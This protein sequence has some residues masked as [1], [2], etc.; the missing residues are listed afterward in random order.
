MRWKTVRTY[1]K[2]LATPLIGYLEEINSADNLRQIVQRLPFH[3]RTK[4]VELADQIQQS[5]QRTNIAHIAEFVKV[6]ARAA[7]K[8][9]FGCVVD[10]VRDRPENLRRNSRGGTS[11]KER[12]S[13]FNTRETGA[14]PSLPS[15]KFTPTLRCPSG[16][17]NHSLEKCNSFKD[18]NFGK[19]MR[20]AQLCFN[21]F[22]Y[23]H[24]GVGR[25]AKSA[26]E[27]QGCRR[28]HHTLL[29]PPSPQQMVETE[30]LTKEFKLTVVLHY[31]VDRPTVPQLE[32]ERCA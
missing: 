23:S 5:G 25:L 11:S 7:N 22:K 16:N 4:L 19:V 2:I 27:I 6:K 20:K 17:G 3:L 26:C 24:I 9:V 28:R 18:K 13:T 15:T 14:K 29:H 1:G 30:W 21:C 12:L 10:V 32:A 31:K 8:P